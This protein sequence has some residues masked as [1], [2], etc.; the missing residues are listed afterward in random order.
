MT[1]ELL[2]ELKVRAEDSA[3]Y[4]FH[5][6]GEW[7]EH[8]WKPHVFYNYCIDCNMQVAVNSSPLPNE[9][10]IGGEVVALNCPGKYDQI[11][12]LNIKE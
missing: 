6:L 8:P 11:R 1:I 2:Q 10:S 7:I 12:A 9:I 5:E 3:N 4:R